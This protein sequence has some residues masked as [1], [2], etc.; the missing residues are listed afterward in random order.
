MD[1]PQ[2]GPLTASALKD[3]KVLDGTGTVAGMASA[4]GQAQSPWPLC[5][6]G[7]LSSERARGQGSAAVTTAHSRWAA[8]PRLAVGSDPGAPP[9]P[10]AHAKQEPRLRGTWVPEGTEPQE[11][12]V[13]VS[14]A[15]PTAALNRLP[16][17]GP[18]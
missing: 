16:W 5:A 18:Q 6:E 8:E 9:L 4:T 15:L 17:P 1:Q 14:K 7:P 2:A 12:P 10:R 13:P 3:W 11:N